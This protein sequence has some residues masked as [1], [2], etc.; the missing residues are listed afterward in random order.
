VAT[1]DKVPFDPAL[2]AKIFGEIQAEGLRAAG[3]LV[4]RLVH[5]VDGPRSDHADESATPSPSAAESAVQ[6]W[7]ELW[8]DL[9]ERTS[10]TVQ[11]LQGAGV[12]PSG[13]GVRIGVDG[14]LAP[15]KPLTLTLGPT[16]HA[17]G[18]M[19]LHNGTAE[20]R[21][22]LVPHCGPL[23]SLDGTPLACEVAIDPPKAEGLPSR[24]SR[25]FTISVVAQ[26]SAAP[27]TYRGLVQVRGA[28]AVWLPLEV[29]VP[30]VPA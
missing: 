17:E 20:D 27:G 25:G 9:I 18:E 16:R 1:V 22:A 11:R 30:E 26:A 2:G 23:C 3:A 5:L 19:W 14:S 4:E 12:G 13:A 15:V 28:D 21:G 7:F 24:S 8:R 6:P 29:V 10:D